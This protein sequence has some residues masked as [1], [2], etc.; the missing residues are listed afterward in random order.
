MDRINPSDLFLVLLYLSPVKNHC[1]HF[2]IIMGKGA[3]HS[4]T[5]S[6]YHII[7]KNPGCYFTLEGNVTDSVS[8]DSQA[9]TIH[10]CKAKQAVTSYFF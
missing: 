5:K 10:Q 4:A 6:Y 9:G 1:R 2:E 7:I 3:A 8:T